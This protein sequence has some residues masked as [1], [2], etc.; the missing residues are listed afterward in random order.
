MA[1]H[2][3]ALVHDQLLSCAAG[4]AKDRE[5]DR[6]SDA[7]IFVVNGFEANGVVSCI[8]SFQGKRVAA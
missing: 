7:M 3:G 4:D 8:G 1:D 5:S 2:G 6:L